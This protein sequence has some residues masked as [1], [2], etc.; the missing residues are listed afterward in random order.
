MVTIKRCKDF[1][2]SI[3]NPTNLLKFGTM[4]EV[5]EADA[6]HDSHI[7]SYRFLIAILASFIHRFR[8]VSVMEISSVFS[9]IGIS[10]SNSCLHL[11]MV[12]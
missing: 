11:F 3:D 2:Y 10:S 4:T 12:L 9:A 5:S 6:V 7:F 8:R 1:M